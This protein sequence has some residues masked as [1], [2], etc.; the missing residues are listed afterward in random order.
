MP[1]PLTVW[2][3]TNWKI[4]KEMGTTDHLTWI[5]RN[6]YIGQKATIITEHGTIIAKGVHQGSML[7]P[8]R[9]HYAKYLAGWS[10]NWNQ[11]CQE[12][13][14]Q[15]QTCRWYHSNGRKWRT[16]EPLD[17]G[18]RGEWKS[19]LKTQHSK[20]TKIMA[21]GPIT[22]QQIDGRKSGNNGRFYFLGLQ[23]HCRWWLQPQ[24]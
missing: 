19:W 1:N 3:T 23:N 17:E 24:N 9:V 4:L 18:E 14:Q 8:C 2:I 15:P 6:L 22:S 5:P 13:Y 16:K 12:K 10:P 11:D 7:S 20:K 21:S